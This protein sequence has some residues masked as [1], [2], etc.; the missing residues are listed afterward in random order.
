MRTSITLIANEKYSQQQGASRHPS[1]AE[2]PASA[3]G[4]IGY[5]STPSADPAPFTSAATLRDALRDGDISAVE[6]TFHYLDRISD[7]ADLGAFITVTAEQALADARAADALRAAGEPLPELHGLPIAHKDLVDVSG[8]PTSLGTAALPRPVAT[9]DHPVVASL[10]AA[11]TISLGKTQVPELGLNAYS[12][13][14]IA[15][16]ARHPL[17]PELTPGGSSGGSAAAVAAGLLPIAPGSDG[18]GSIRIPALACG[19]VGLKPGLGTV[20]G[21]VT[22][23]THD[24]FGAPRLTVSG[25]LAHTAADAALLLDAMTAG[26]TRR[27]PSSPGP[28]SVAVHRAH[29]LAGL[30]VAMS[31]LSPFSYAFDIALSPDARRAYDTA[32]ARLLALGHRVDPAHFT[33]DPDYT[34]FF[35]SGWIAG[36]TLLELEP[37][38]EERLTPL[39]QDFR[40][41][42]LARSTEQHR[43][44]AERMRGFAHVVREMWGQSDV[45]LTPGLAMDPP[46]VGE[47]MSLSPSDDY[48]LQ[49]RWTPYTSMV[50]VAGLPAVAVPILTS[51]RDLSFGVQLIGREGSE[52]QLLALA[53]QLMYA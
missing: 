16:P 37:G 30:T 34:D 18:G 40:R 11:G 21:D 15:P 45:V 47:F 8:V 29:D 4:T 9:S 39:T 12:E 44:A 43:A 36:L 24:D 50:N 33:Y 13:N 23:G 1:R 26:A 19:L 51:E 35:T 53:E 27:D 28:H 20:P 41:R 32:A 2:T 17:H 10:R 14:L 48:E 52:A 25:P 5:M 42:A 31:E 6:A 22:L 46:A 38:A 7:R 3:A 49:C